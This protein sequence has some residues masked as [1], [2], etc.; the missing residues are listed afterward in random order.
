VDPVAAALN[1]VRPLPRHAPA[2]RLKGLA[3]DAALGPASGGSATV[4][5][6][7]VTWTGPDHQVFTGRSMDWSYGFNCHFHVFPRAKRLDSAGGMNSLVV[8][9]VC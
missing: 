4:A 7:G 8:F 2:R 6:S 1:P 3:A 5:C 9:T